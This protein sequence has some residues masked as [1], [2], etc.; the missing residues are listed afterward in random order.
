MLTT[1]CHGSEC[2]RTTRFKLL[3]SGQNLYAVTS[4]SSETPAII[5]FQL[6]QSTGKVTEISANLT[7]NNI[8]DYSYGSWFD[9]IIDNDTAYWVPTLSTDSGSVVEIWSYELQNPKATAQRMIPELPD[10]GGELNGSFIS[11]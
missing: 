3:S 5:I 1:L 4:P 8:D 9:V 10:Y 6:D 11:T 2:E 7:V